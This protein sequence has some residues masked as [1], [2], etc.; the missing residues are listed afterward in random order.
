MLSARDREPLLVIRADADSRMGTGHV[1]RCL[2]L[3][4]AWQERGGRVKLAGR[5]DS[6]SL[7]QW[8]AAQGV[9]L[10]ELASGPP[11]ADDPAW[12][13]ALRRQVAGRAAESWIAL[14]GYQ[15]EHAC[16]QRLRRSGLKLLVID[17]YAHLP[18]YDADLLLNQNP[19]SEKLHY[20]TP[21]ET[22]LL[23]GGRYVL[24]RREFLQARRAEV[25]D[26]PALATRLLV[27]LGG[28]DPDNV[29]LAVL[30]ALQLLEPP[31]QAKIVAGPANPHL[32]LLREW[33]QGRALAA[34]LRTDVADMAPLMQWA[35][36]AVTAGGGT[37]WE[38][39]C[40][41]VPALVVTLADNQRGV[42]QAMAA[43][44]AGVDLGWHHGLTPEKLACAIGE[45]AR[46][47]SRRQA[48]RVAGRALVDGLG[49]DRVAECMLSYP[50]AFRPAEESDCRQVFAWANDPVI[51]GASFQ[52][53]A[54]SWPE[55]EAWFAR[56]LADPDTRF[57]IIM[58]H[59]DRPAGQVRF[60]SHNEEA[61]IS[62]SLAAEYRGAGLGSLVI[63]TACRRLSAATGI[64]VVHARIR[65][66]NMQS[67]K[68]F[69]RAGFVVESEEAV[70]GVPA[71]HMSLRKV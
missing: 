17:D 16:Q 9:E 70:A 40:L 20:Q 54:I 8:L 27:T 55:H 14:D 63:G 19:G 62:I 13:D 60:V 44:G 46:D 22:V 28:A 34:E 67:I 52:P 7:R 51:R 6:Q 26:A 57:W 37:C 61:V 11:A 66:D 68:S 3:A 42:A 50:F 71:L 49:A 58:L 56:T 36:L 41:G 35:D 12:L 64:S 1:M 32:A 43:G 23:R 25:A 30:A 29:T 39:A 4:R 69:T 15:F 2:A 48:M 18:A 47:R 38:L 24:L 45:L 59:G 33:L 53:Q 21:P 10:I 65:K 31:V 5:V